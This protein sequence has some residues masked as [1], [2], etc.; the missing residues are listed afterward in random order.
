[1][2]SWCL[3]LSAVASASWLCIQPLGRFR[4]CASNEGEVML[5][6]LRYRTGAEAGARNN[7]SC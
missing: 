4:D 3:Y 5:R 7:S 6:R 1:M 2:S